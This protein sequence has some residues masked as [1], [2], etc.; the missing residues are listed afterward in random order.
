LRERLPAATESQQACPEPFG[1]AQDKLAEGM[2][3]LQ[4]PQSKREEKT[5]AKGKTRWQAR[6]TLS[7][8][9]LALDG[10]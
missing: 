7:L 8:L 4:H 1:F 10:M 5:V 3:L 6:L 9:F 2:A